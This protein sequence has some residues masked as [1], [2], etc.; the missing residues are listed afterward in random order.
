M[1]SPQTPQQA[2]LFEN[3]AKPAKKKNKQ[4]QLAEDIAELVGAGREW[5]L[6]TVDF[7]DPNRPKTCL[8]VDFP[9]VP[10]NEIASIEGSSGSTRKP[11]YQVTKWWARRNSSIFRSMLLAAAAKAPDDESE[12]ASL[13]WNA[14]YGNHQKNEAFHNLKVAEPFMGGGTTLVEGSRLGMQLFGCDL[15]PVA[16]FV[17]KNEITPVDLDEVK[18][19]L[20]EIE[21]EVKPYIMPYF[22]CDGPHGEKGQWFQKDG[23]EQGGWKTLPE[24]FDI[25]S[26]PWQERPNFRYEGPEIIYTFWAKHGPCA[27][28]GCGHRT[29]LFPTPVVAIKTLTVKCWKDFSCQNCGGEFDVEQ[30]EARMAPDWPLAI[31]EDETPF[32]AMNTRG[33][34]HCPHCNQQHTDLAG[35]GKGDSVSLGGKAK[36]KKVDL[37]LLM[38]PDWLKGYGS[39]DKQGNPLGGSATDDPDST[40]R[41]LKKRAEAL[42]LVEVRGKLPDDVTCPKTGVTFSTGKD[43]GNIPKKSTFSCQEKTCGRQQD[44]LDSIK[45]S[46]KTGPQSPYVFQGFSSERKNSGFPYSGRFFSSFSNASIHCNAVKE[47]TDRAQNDL[48]FYW[49]KESLPN[50]GFMTHMN[51]GGIPNHGF[52]HWWKFFNPVQLLIHTQILKAIENKLGHRTE[53]LEFGLAIF[54]QYLRNQSLLTIWDRGADQLTPAL[55]NNNFHPKSTTIENNVFNNLGRGNWASCKNKA[56]ESIYWTKNPNELVSNKRAESLADHNLKVT[57]KSTRVFTNDPLR[58]EVQCHCSSATD[59]ALINDNEIDLVITDPPFGGLLHYSE[60]SDYFYVW[61]RI[62]LKDKYP[63][64]FQSEESPKALEAVSNRARQDEPGAFYRQILTECWKESYRILKPGGLLAFTF[65]H[66]EDDPWVDVLISLFEAGFYLENTFPIRSDETKGAGSKPGTFGS[67]QIEYDI[68]HVCRKRLKEPTRVSWARLRRRIME[69]VRELKKLLEQHSNEGLPDA[70]LRV[71]KRGK[72][73]EYYSQHYG[74]VFVEHGREFTLKEALV[75]INQLLDDEEEQKEDAPPITAEA[76]TRQFLRI[77]RRTD[78]VASDQMQKT[79]RGTGMAPSD[80]EKRGWCKKV[81]KV[82]HMVQPLE[83]A[84]QWKGQNRKGMA[85]DLDQ[86]LFLVGA[87]YEDSGINVWDT[88]NS[89]NFRHHPAIPE[90]LVWFGSNGADDTVKASSHRAH[91][92]YLDWM[93]RHKDEVEEAQAEFDFMEE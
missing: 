40:T 5:H 1:A 70:D 19:L 49:P 81:K 18:R 39:I 22:A 78:N 89:P 79:L 16:W 48:K 3:S 35:R 88:L 72:A 55:S 57:G 93:E 50:F 30:F 80:F 82:F 46:L 8:E 47:W 32:A 51:N 91:R 29:P 90:L 61:L 85:R 68:I 45:R 67:Q 14:Y 6:D 54:Q 71:I 7:S 36:S 87:C 52:T 77:F 83:W 13:V 44:V 69:D 37:S 12:A 73:L 74:Q 23:S 25:F 33:E 43:G 24:D 53:L 27:A 15:N 59:M 92:I 75:G 31:A 20:A 17:V 4:E 65:H 21:E 64:Y 42:R 76:F 62:L 58:E 11:I 63:H 41:W 10:I 9:I 56:L 34:F 60:L 86:T 2:S 38:H 26:I 28:Q 84:G 66:S